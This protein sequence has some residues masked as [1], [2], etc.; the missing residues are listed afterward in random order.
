[1]LFNPEPTTLIEA[2]DV[3]IISGEQTAIDQLDHLAVSRG[4]NA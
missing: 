2:G 1:M 4:G 3:L